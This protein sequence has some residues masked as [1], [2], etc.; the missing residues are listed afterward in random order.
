MR[1][2]F[3]ERPGGKPSRL[4]RGRIEALYAQIEKWVNRFSRP[5]RKILSAAK[6]GRR[7][8]GGVN[9]VIVSTLFA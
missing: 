9:G 6:T 7:A 1:V 3:H 2:R 4:P 8:W 5:K